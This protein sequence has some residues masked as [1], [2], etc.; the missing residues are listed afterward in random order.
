MVEEGAKRASGI[1]AGLLRLSVGLEDPEDLWRDLDRA[2]ATAHQATA[3][4]TLGT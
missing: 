3:P 1:S 2:L 4:G